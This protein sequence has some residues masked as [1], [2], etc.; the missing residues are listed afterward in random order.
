MI[1]IGISLALAFG[2]PDAGWTL[3]LT[4]HAIVERSAPIVLPWEP[5]SPR[6]SIAFPHVAFVVD[7]C[8]VASVADHERGHLDQY[9]ALGP[10]VGVAY[11]LTGGQAIEDYLGPAGTTWFPPAGDRPR[12]PLLRVDSD[13]GASFMPCWRP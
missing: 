2:P 13:A 12:C 6:C 4:G 3:D 9:H 10:G 11:A 5:G 8:D 7:R 1:E